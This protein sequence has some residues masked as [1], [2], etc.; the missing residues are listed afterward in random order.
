MGEHNIPKIQLTIRVESNGQINI[1]GPLTDKIFCLG[2][3]EIAK[4]IVHEYKVPEPNRLI[5]PDFIPP[6]QMK[7]GN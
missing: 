3:L 1:H 5:V 6:G 4:K 7:P 2:L